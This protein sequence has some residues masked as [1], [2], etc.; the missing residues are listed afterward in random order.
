VASNFST[1]GATSFLAGTARPVFAETQFRLAIAGGLAPAKIDSGATQAAVLGGSPP[2]SDQI[3]ALASRLF[4]NDL[5]SASTAGRIRRS[6]V[7]SA[8]NETWDALNFS[9]AEAR[10]DA[11]VAIRENSNELFVFGETTLQ[12]FTPDPVS[13][14]APG[15][16]VNR[17]CAAAGSVIR[18]DEHFAWLDDQDQFVVSDG[19][20]GDVPSD[21]IAATIESIDTVSDCWG[22]RLN[23]DQ[24]DLLTWK[25]PTDGRTLAYQR[26]SG[27]AQWSG[28]DETIGGHTVLPVTAHYYW[29]TERLHLAGLDDGRVVKFDP[30]AYTDL[31]ETIK[32]EVTTGFINRGTDAYKFTDAL[33]LTFKR[34]RSSS[35]EP[36]VFLSWR[37][38]EGAF[39]SPIS[40]GLGTTGD[41]V[42][43]VTKRTLGG[44]RRRQWKLEFSSDAELVLASVTEDFT[45][46]GA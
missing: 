17:G 4:T 33:H 20:S 5:T 22:F 1:S 31:V 40:I 18:A 39:G 3:A 19:R 13:I 41:Y 14:L 46:G 43:T 32:A 34:G 11:V 21:P 8:G 42:S 7:A 28:Y 25:F 35:T 45:I 6:G 36:Q 15:R 29:P 44:Y 2:D 10:P 9:T 16:A 30:A 27:W 12:V 26:G 24:F 23:I 38:D 37:D